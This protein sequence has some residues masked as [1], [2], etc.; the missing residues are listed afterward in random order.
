[1][2][3]RPKVNKTN[4]TKINILA[5]G[6]PDCGQQTFVEQMSKHFSSSSYSQTTFIFTNVDSTRSERN[7][8]PQIYNET[9]NVLCVFFFCDVSTSGQ[10]LL[11]LKSL[12]WLI[13]QLVDSKPPIVV[14][15]VKKAHDP[16]FIYL[17]EQCS[18]T[19]LQYVEGSN[20]DITQFVE[21]VNNAMTNFTP[22]PEQ[23]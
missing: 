17:K 9:N 2:R 19:P 13:S 22:Q 6:L 3:D 21:V 10:V 7:K 1:M 11:S 20:N 15:K 4:Q 23:K 8:W 12:N 14:A 5:Y 16:N 18:I